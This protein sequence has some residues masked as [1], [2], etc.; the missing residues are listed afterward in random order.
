MLQII[1]TTEEAGGCAP[2][3]SSLADVRVLVAATVDWSRWSD[4]LR[5]SAVGGLCVGVLGGF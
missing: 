4:S 1:E 3:C 5:R 2:G